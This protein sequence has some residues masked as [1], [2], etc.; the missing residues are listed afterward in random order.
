M[1]MGCDGQTGPVPSRRRV[2]VEDPEPVTSADAETVAGA[3]RHDALHDAQVE[4]LLHIVQW[5]K[6][7]APPPPGSGSDG[8]RKQAAPSPDP[9]PDGFWLV[10]ASFADAVPPSTHLALLPARATPGPA[11]LR[12][13][14]EER[15][16]AK[17]RVMLGL[18]VPDRLAGALAGCSADF[19]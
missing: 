4:G 17:R 12:G 8:K 14:S 6:P 2:R 9:N 10:P 16:E 3:A 19:A 5:I 15:A 7:A 18:D 1:V 13:T 11:E